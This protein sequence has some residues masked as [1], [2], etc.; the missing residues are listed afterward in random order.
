MITLVMVNSDD[1]SDDA[2]DNIKVDENDDNNEIMRLRD[3][4]L[5]LPL[6]LRDLHI[7]AFTMIPS[8]YYAT[9]PLCYYA[10]MLLCHMHIEAFTVI[11]S[12]YHATVTMLV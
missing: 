2:D 10:T 1:R 12:H 7:E 11:S 3:P 8:Y 5:G 9:M 6:G 4:Q